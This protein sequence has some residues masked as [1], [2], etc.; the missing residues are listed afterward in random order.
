MISLSALMI[1]FWAGKLIC[2]YQFEKKVFCIEERADKNARLIKVFYL[3]MK[4]KQNGKH[5]SSFLKD[6]GFYKV[7]IYGMHFLGECLYDEL[8]E[9]DITVLYGIDKNATKIATN[10]RIVLPEDKLE[11]VDAIIVTPAFYF[12]EIERQLSQ[13]ISCPIISIE[14]ILENL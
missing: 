3:W 10:I 12:G 8:K 2:Q 14:D 7:A 13:K 4:H 9:T 11:K 5:I 1:S 6:K